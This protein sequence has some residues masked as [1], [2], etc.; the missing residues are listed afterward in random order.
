MY[1]YP[2]NFYRSGH[3]DTIVRCYKTTIIQRDHIS[4]ITALPEAKVFILNKFCSL[5]IETTKY[6]TLLQISVRVCG[7]GITG[8]QNHERRVTDVR[9]TCT[10]VTKNK[11][12]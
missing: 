12:Y 8:M 10:T 3:T 2:K 6:S 11:K 1:T 7:R 5:N 9:S 4:D